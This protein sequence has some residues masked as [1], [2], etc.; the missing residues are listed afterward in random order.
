MVKIFKYT[1]ASTLEELAPQSPANY[2]STVASEPT[3]AVM[4]VNR[5]NDPGFL[6]D[7]FKSCSF[8]DALSGSPSSGFPD[9]RQC[10]FHVLD[11]SHVLI[12]LFNDLDY[13]RIFCHRF[14]LVN[15]Y[16][17][18]IS[19]WSPLL[20]ISIE[21]P[22]IPI[23]VSFPNLRPHLFTP[24]IFH[25]LGSMF[26]RPLNVDSA[27]SVGSRPSLARV[28]VELDITKN[29]PDKI[30]LG[31]D[32]LGYIQSV[33][34]EVFPGFCDHCKPIGHK[35][36]ECR[37]VSS[38]P[39]SVPIIVDNPLRSVK[40]DAVEIVT[41]VCNGCDDS[42]H[43]VLC[44]A[45]NL[46]NL[47][48][49]SMVTELTNSIPIVT[50][51]PVS[52]PVLSTPA[53]GLGCAISGTAISLGD[54]FFAPVSLPV[55]TDSVMDSVCEAV[56]GVVDIQISVVS[57]E[58]LKSH[59]AWSLNNSVLL[60]TN[61]LEMDESALTPSVGKSDDL[62]VH[63]ND[64]MYNFMVGCVV[65]QAVLYGGGKRKKSKAKKK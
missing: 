46:V 63:V 56:L 2:P 22:V 6:N 64:D 38:N 40:T 7:S 25:S 33:V 8:V 17:M 47:V 45:G 36:G 15:N 41:S 4:A 50:D 48:A 39:V 61:W 34:M 3:A 65:D 24:R 49:M 42:S 12:K 28:L 23:W 27:T 32:K 43:E 53:V 59:A 52:F 31:P 57:N 62:A 18:K 5:V 44:N 60:Q 54:S 30:W 14:Y 29:F 51:A 58:E 26:G 37:I 9:L 21:S 1:S 35:R 19:K 10:S 55:L 11:Q 16:F 13:S 20:D